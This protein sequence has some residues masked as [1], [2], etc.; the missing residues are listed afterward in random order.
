MA[1]QEALSRHLAGGI[2][3]VARC[4]A[5]TRRDGVVFG[6]TDHDL[7]L[8]FDGISFAASSGLTARALQ[9]GTG[10]SVDNTEAIGAL[11]HESIREEDINA[12]R[13]D[14]AEVTA[15]LV[16]WQNVAERVV[17]FRGTLGEI[18]RR[19]GQF[20]AEL[21]GLTEALNQTRG[22]VYQRL[23]SAVL[24]DAACAFDLSEP[25]YSTEV[26]VSAS[27][28][29]RVLD[30]GGLAS[31][32]PGWFTRGT[33]EAVD[34]AAQGLRETIKEDRGVGTDRRI[35]LWSDMRAPLVAGD[36]VRLVAG[37]DKRFQTCKQKFG[38]QLN[39]RGFPDIPGDDWLI[40]YPVRAG[41]NDG[42][43]L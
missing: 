34:G 9:Q 7:P 27:E 29:G 13:F 4:W 36:R 41:V 32:A 22:R 15:W 10:L 33:I 24:G 18:Q 40:S 26:P 8:A 35:V 31:F 3:T 37:C 17:Q 21:R 25:G 20:T 39:F 42:G 2:T 11:S 38:N 14:G 19:D 23:C 30:L 43:A 16:N 28:D 12:G 6:F 5:V 1:G